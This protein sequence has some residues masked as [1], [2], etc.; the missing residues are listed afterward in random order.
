[1][2]HYTNN[3]NY[4]GFHLYTYNGKP[5]DINKN[6]E[7]KY[8]PSGTKGPW[9]TENFNNKSILVINPPEKNGT[10]GYYDFQI[11]EIENDIIK[12]RFSI[13][14]NETGE[15]VNDDKDQSLILTLNYLRNAMEFLDKA[16]NQCPFTDENEL[17]KN[18]SNLRHD[19]RRLFTYFKALNYNI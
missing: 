12:K 14:D 17:T 7:V 2:E 6:Y 18:M 9:I 16:Y 15:V 13:I 19:C 11:R 4:S 8:R 3:V 10:N 5:I 1:M